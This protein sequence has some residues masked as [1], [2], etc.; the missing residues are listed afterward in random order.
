MN[1]ALWRKALLESRW[2]LLG[3]AVAICATMF[4]R[5]WIASMLRIG[6]LRRLLRYIP[7]EFVDFIAVPH[8]FFITP[9]GQVAIGYDLPMVWAVG[10][11]WGIAR[12][13]DVVS[14]E[15]GR[16]TMEMLLAQPV[17]RL[18]ILFVATIVMIL[19]A[20][21]LALS[22]WIGV[23][24]GSQSFETEIPI[25]TTAFLPAAANLFSLIVFISG[26][27][28]LCSSFDRYRSRT[29]GLAVGLVVVA[30]VL[31][32]IALSDP[33]YYQVGF[34]SFFTC[35]DPQQLVYQFSPMQLAIDE[36]SA[37]DLLVRYNSI[38]IGIGLGSFVLA[39]I[40]FSGRDLPTPV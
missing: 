32:M 3:C 8:D 13:S 37:W 33:R 1:R 31:K 23:F 17:R 39:G 16:G 26:V 7:E 28:T 24:V 9:A 30:V 5:A 18:S 40:T 22:S 36:A 15:I 25:P 6:H 19:G 35:Y 27:T 2:L 14:G 21:V 4:V 38:L 29:I 34:G 10:C 20:I 11:A 12:G